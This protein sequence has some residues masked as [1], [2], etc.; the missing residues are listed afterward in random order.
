MRDRR[1][2]HKLA[3]WRLAALPGQMVARQGSFCRS[4]EG[5]RI[6]LSGQPTCEAVGVF[7]ASPSTATMSGP[8]RITSGASGMFAR[9]SL[10]KLTSLLKF[11]PS[12]L[13]VEQH[14]MAGAL[15]DT[16]DSLIRKKRSELPW[17]A[18]KP[19]SARF[20]TKGP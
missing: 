16:R 10:G 2:R 1:T 13:C 15:D 6:H 18:A 9:L 20:V 12:R 11:S 17:N 5:T 19:R 8:N 3:S 4:L 14:T 7:R